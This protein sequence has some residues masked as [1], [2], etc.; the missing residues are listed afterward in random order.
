MRTCK[1]DGCNNPVFGGGVCRYHGYTRHMKGGDLFK[2]KNNTAVTLSPKSNTKIPKES[3]TRKK[4]GKTYKEVKDELRA[5]LK[6]EGKYDCFFCTDPMGEE[7]G[8]HHLKGRDGDNFIDKRWLVP[9]H[10]QCHVWDYH[11]L[12]VEQLLQFPWYQGFLTRLKNKDPKL[13]REELKK[14][15]KSGLIFDDEDELFN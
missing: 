1:I 6:A 9:G 2:P 13:L 7:K 11:H 8:F 4:Q 15:E 12:C 3:K 5:E 14:Q 10:N